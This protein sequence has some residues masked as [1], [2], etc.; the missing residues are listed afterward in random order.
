MQN[1]TYTTHGPIVLNHE[2]SECPSHDPS[3]CLDNY[4]VSEMVKWYPTIKSTFTHIVPIAVA[5]NQTQPYV[6][7][8]ITFPDF[9][10]YTSS[11]AS[12]SDG[13]SSASSSATASASS[14][15]S[16]STVSPSSSGSTSQSAAPSTSKASGGI[17]TVNYKVRGFSSV[18]ML[19]GGAV[20]LMNW[21]A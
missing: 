12:A 7:T 5:I 15:S 4:T 9:S 1:G 8:N 21:V 14:S 11:R 2:L 3:D 6:E 10:Q 16:A 19:A 18:V 20:L 17:G 13:S